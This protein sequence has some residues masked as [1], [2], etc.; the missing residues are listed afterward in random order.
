MELQPRTTNNEDAQRREPAPP[1][2]PVAVAV[3]EQAADQQDWGTGIETGCTDLPEGSEQDSEQGSDGVLHLSQSLG[4]FSNTKLYLWTPAF[5][6]LCEQLR[7]RPSTGEKDGSYFVRGP[8]RA[9]NPTRLDT[10]IEYA[11]LIPLDGDSRL[12]P[13]TGEITEGAPHPL[14]VHKTLAELDINHVLYTTYSH[15]HSEKGNRFRVLIPAPAHD[16]GE[17]TG[18]LRWIFHLLNEKGCWLAD[19]KE[20]HTWSQP[21]FFP[22]LASDDSEYLCFVH[23]TG[24]IFD[25]Q[26]ASDWYAA[27]LPLASKELEL[28]VRTA[29]P[30]DPD[31]VFAR[32]NAKHGNPEQMLA[33]L[34]SQGYSRVSQSAINGSVS[35]R[36]LSPHS[37]TGNAGIILFLAGDGV[38]RVY[39]H[40]GA[41]E[42][43]SRDGEDITTS[44]AWDLY[45]IFEHSNDEQQGIFAW[46]E[47]SDTRPV[48]KIRPGRIGPNLAATVK[49][50]AQKDPPTVYQRTQLL[51]RVAHLQETGETQGCSIPKGTA[52]IVTLHRSGLTV[53]A[54]DAAVWKKPKKNG[55]WQNADPCPKIIAAL[56]E[57][58]G[59]WGEI[60]MLLGISEAPILRQDGSLLAEPGYDAAT[61]LY[62]EGRFPT[63]TLPETVSL[64]Q[65]KEAAES[66]LAPFREFP[67]VDPA[68]DLSVILAYLFTLALRPQLPT[69]PLF[70]VS[71]TTPGTGKGLI[72]EVCNLIV[73]GRDAATM[74]PVQGSAG[75]DE[76]RKRITA[77]FLQGI[78]SINLDNWSK[79]IGGESMN[80]MLIASEWTDRV[81]GA[82]TTVSLV[83]AT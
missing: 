10:N 56:L 83:L 58:V 55:E 14:S 59:K 18:Y 45:R 46:E 26:A 5:P 57:A 1:L 73:R 65:A 27:E 38:W 4:G 22:R 77:L 12:D 16:P 31:S 44:D 80:A 6:E 69:A 20:N 8:C 78:A 7:R 34:E 19:V 28:A 72:I 54:S 32:F 37:D 50:L 36:L 35:Y 33:V 63:F 49:A 68:A 40:H 47:A 43:L 24:A 64:E 25:T 82:S 11:T 79:P 29:A 81:L 67:F 13:D 2:E 3:R 52:H 17:L 60:P 9:D 70:C 61:R 76:T 39:S 66:L 62:V 21:G 15:G 30:R 41:D 75:E 74:P 48:I 71:A 42:P 53:E 23:D 51:C